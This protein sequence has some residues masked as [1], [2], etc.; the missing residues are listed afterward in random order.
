[1]KSLRAFKRQANNLRQKQNKLTFELECAEHDFDE[2]P[3]DDTWRELCKAEEASRKLSDQLE[4]I[5]EMV[6]HY[7]FYAYCEDE[8]ETMAM[9]TELAYA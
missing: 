7:D 5:N 3:C 8:E 4:A 1:M 6:E 9:R 2:N